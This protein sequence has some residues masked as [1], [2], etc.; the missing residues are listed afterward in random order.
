MDTLEDFLLDQ[1]ERLISVEVFAPGVKKIIVVSF[2]GEEALSSLSRFRLEIVSQGRPL[3]PSEILGQKLGIALRVRDEVRKFHGIVSRFEVLRT[4]VRGYHLHVVE[5]VPPAW[6]MTLNRR[7]RIF[8]D[9][10]SHQVIEQVLSEGGISFKPK[11]VGDQREYWVQYGESDFTLVSRLWEDEGLFYRF[12][13]ESPTCDLIVGN[14]A[15][16]YAGGNPGMLVAEENLLSWQ[17]RYRVGSSAF[18]H[19]AWDFKEVAVMGAQVNGLAKAQPPALSA[20]QVSEY[21]GRHETDG[22]G[23]RL[24]TARMEAEEAS[25]V[26]VEGVSID[27]RLATGTRHQ[28]PGHAIDLPATGQTAGSFVTTRVVHHAR[29]FS[30]LPFEGGT[31][32]TNDFVSIPADFPYRPPRDTPRPYIGGP[33]TATVTDTPDEHGRCKVKFHWD[34]DDTSRWARVAQNWA[35]NK[36]G[37]QFFARIDSEV[38]VEFLNG[39]PDHPI[40]VGMVYNG[41]NKPPFDVPANKTQ[42]GWRGANWGDAGTPDVSN[43]IRFEDKAGSEEI[44]IHA[45]KDFK[46]VVHHDDTLIVETGN[47]SID[48]Q[49]GNLT[50][51]ID[52]GNASY[53][54]SMGNSKTQLDMGNHDLNLDMGAASTTA[55]QSITLTVGGSSIKIDQMGVTIKGMMIKIDG[56]VSVDVNSILTTVKADAILTLKGGITMIN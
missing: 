7:Y 2:E 10:A 11:A 44:Y 6:L 31:D 38:V 22:E 54:L 30:Q 13:H 43:E 3:K 14:G 28:V 20:R 48:I 51:K 39:D 29:D 36:M 23:S 50:E 49:Q 52:Q 8:H 15:A 16:D 41:K 42:S 12:D 37:V 55:M 9:K 33:Q 45:Q 18:R 5:L 27:C 46:R 25:L 24:A 56:D 1:T 26:W 21:P 53:T 40:I 19:G 34:E 4:S 47:R 17:P 32:Y 35:Y